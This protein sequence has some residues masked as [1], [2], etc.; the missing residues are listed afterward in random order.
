M[1]SALPLQAL[2]LVPTVESPAMCCEGEGNQEDEEDDEQ[3]HDSFPFCTHRIW[4]ERTPYSLFSFNRVNVF[5]LIVYLEKPEHASYELMM[6]SEGLNI[7][8]MYEAGLVPLRC[9]FLE[10]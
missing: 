8:R 10:A 6:Y 9:R 7:I 4:A 2:Q 1:R 3:Y 5:L